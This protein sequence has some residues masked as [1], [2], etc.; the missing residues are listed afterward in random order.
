MFEMTDRDGLARLGRFEVHGRI[1]E[2]PALLPVVNPHHLLVPPTRLWDNF[3]VR[4][5]ITNAYILLRGHAKEAA[6]EQ[7][8]HRHLGFPGLI[9]T[10]SGAFQSHVY[11]DVKVTPQGIMEFQASLGTDVA[12]VL[13]LFSEPEHDRARAE[14]D[15]RETLAR[16]Q[17]AAATKGTVALAGAVQGGL[18]PDLR[19]ECARRLSAM[20][21]DVHAIGGVVPL[22][23]SYR[24]RDLQEVIL[25]S[26]RGLAPHRPV[27]LFGAGHPMVFPLAVLLG[28]DLFDSA[29]Y[30]KYALDGRLLFPDGTRRAE[31]L[32]ELPC[33]CPAC[34]AAGLQGMKDSL[35]ARA[36]HNLWVSLAEVRRVRQAIHEGSLWELVEERARCHPALMEALRALRGH[37]A[38]LEKYDNLS[39]RTFFF[40]GPESLQ[41]PS[42]V[43]FR[44]RV[45][46]RYHPPPKPLLVILPEAEKPYPDSY[47]AL[48]KEL[49]AVAD[50]HFV[51]QS[52]LGA[53]PLELSYLYPVGQALVPRDL[54]AETLEAAEVFLQQYVRHGP[55]HFGV[56]WGDGALEELRRRA[57]GPGAW[58]FDMAIVHATA[59][60]QFREE[61]ARA[62]LDGR[63]ELV[64]SKN[65]RRIRNVL[66]D[67]E[68][69][70]SLRAE[71]GLFSL[72]LAGG[73]RLQRKL[74]SPSQRVVVDADAAP[75]NREGKNVFAKFVK[76]MDAELRPGDQVLVVTEDDELLAVGRAFMVRAEALAFRQGVAVRVRE[77]VGPRAGEAAEG[78]G[79]ISTAWNP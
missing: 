74:P 10:D 62:L 47:A 51:V 3:R 75:F 49:L 41:R 68:H 14:A 31:D 72:R 35:E 61:G 48:A 46:H 24:F 63:V 55:H 18:H 34:T 71:D 15:V 56:R 4:A 69:V 38:F 39:R 44:Q 60:Y 42:A 36:E 30:A 79:G 52:P 20:D 73:R 40:T 19:E 16:T 33:T 58:D 50:V 70:L 12:T 54:D 65:T 28:C 43:R 78:K 66:V 23:E 26:R 53:V 5:I 6:M 77:G 1:V 9:M 64:K 59:E 25:A 21:V 13:D 27:H 7:G 32:V 67:G 29:S 8:L 22:M 76:E 57:G 37:T 17:E 2:T 11:G 45:L